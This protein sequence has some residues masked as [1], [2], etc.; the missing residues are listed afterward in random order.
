V[1]DLELTEQAV[2]GTLRQF[3]D[4]YHDPQ[5]WAAKKIYAHNRIWFADANEAEAEGR[6]PCSICG[7]RV[8][9]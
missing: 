7:G 6:V 9:K 2:I 3:S 5:C 1:P 4:R 8:P